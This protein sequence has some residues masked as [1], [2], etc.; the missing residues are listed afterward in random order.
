MRFRSL[1]NIALLLGCSSCLP[2]FSTLGKVPEITGLKP[3]GRLHPGDSITLQFSC[4][5]DKSSVESALRLFS[6]T[7]PVN[8]SF[9]WNSSKEVAFFPDL[10]EGS[11]RYILELA[12]TARS[13]EGIPLARRYR[14]FFNRSA[15][16]SPLRIES[17]QPNPDDLVISP[18]AEFLISFNQ[19]VERS[20]FYSA[21]TLSPHVE[22]GYEWNGDDTQ[23]RIIPHF[24]LTP[25]MHYQLKIST[26]CTGVGGL[27]L[28]SPVRRHYAAAPID[29]LPIES[30]IWSSD[31]VQRSA[32][33]SPG[34]HYH[35]GQNEAFSIRF[36]EAVPQALHSAAVQLQPDPGM[37]F[38]WTPDN[39]QCRLHTAAPPHSDTVFHLEIGNE[40]YYLQW[41]GAG[42]E[43][44]AL[45]GVAY[46]NDISAA[47]ANFRRIYLNDLL[48]FESSPQ[49]ALELAFSHAPQAEVSALELM[50]ALRLSA[51]NGA[52]A[53]RLS[54]LQEIES[55]E[56]AALN[57]L[58][59]ESIFR[60]SFSIQR[61]PAAGRLCLQI[62]RDLEDSCGNSPGSEISLSY[63]L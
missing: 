60:L 44:V 26:E 13:S 55:A 36:T 51:T 7:L 52:A 56:C 25:Q 27:P 35:A 11:G 42:T 46:C 41:D 63:N 21:C 53:L 16:T 1:L 31:G 28:A 47:P 57:A 45:A 33:A 38:Q 62:A 14:H 54:G 24:G 17:I 23:V 37:D 12:Y 59:P 30:F 32:A 22:A 20:T 39:R 15:D 40:S 61:Y 43:P 18:T 8:G 2:F 48:D 50:Q 58:K 34:T 9:T 29:T 19:A 6:S 4:D 3:V 10:V 5:M 49:A